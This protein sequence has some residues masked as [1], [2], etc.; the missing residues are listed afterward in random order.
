MEE[1]SLEMDRSISLL[2]DLEQV[3]QRLGIPAPIVVVKGDGTLMSKET[4]LERPVETILSGPAA[5]VAGARHLTGRRDAIVVDMGGTTTDTAMLQDGQV[6]VCESGSL[7]GGKK[8][9]VRALRIRTA[10]LGGDSFI[11]WNEGR[12]RI[13]PQRVAPMA[14]LGAQGPGV[15]PALDFLTR[16]LEDYKDSTNKMQILTLQGLTDD[17]PLTAREADIV[18]LLEERPFSLQELAQRT[19][20]LHWSFVPVARLEE[21]FIIQRCGL[22]PTDLLNS[23]GK[24]ALWDTKTSRRMCEAF[25]EITGMTAQEMIR[26]LLD[27]MV[28]RLALEIV[29]RQLDEETDSDRLG[30]RDV[31][32]VLIKNMLGDGSRDYS[33]RMVLHKPVIGIGAPVHLFL[34]EAASLLGAEAIVPEHADV[35]NAIGAVTSR[36]RV[37]RQVKVRPSQAGGFL[38]EGLPGA[39][40]FLDREE[41]TIHARAG[42]IRLV[43]EL[44]LAAGT[45][46]TSVE[47]DVD[48]H[49]YTTAEGSPIFICRTLSAELMGEPDRILERQ[50]GETSA[51]EGYREQNI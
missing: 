24:T 32:R 3:L 41:A 16:R 28:K 30:D 4:A 34:D 22:T 40:R 10:G 20:L 13:G 46:E 51:E 21:Y 18:R 49:I 29:K 36:V 17:L 45:G 23:R 19:G 12:Y 35:A 50:K 7:V 31:C 33:L 14:W 25:G 37:R 6:G 2:E 1:M 9:H 8:T 27:E 44:A 43:Q 47:I 42:L 5:S 15:G 39:K 26:S 11:A 38:I 48:D